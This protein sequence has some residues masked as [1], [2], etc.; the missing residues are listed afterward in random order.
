M[1]LFVSI[2]YNCG[3]LRRYSEAID[4]YSRAVQLK[5]DFAVGWY[6]VGLF[7]F[8]QHHYRDAVLASEKALA[9]NPDYDAP[10]VIIGMEHRRSGDLDGA[11]WSFKRAIDLNPSFVEAHVNL[12]ETYLRRNEID[13]A[14]RELQWAIQSAP[15]RARIYRETL[16]L[17]HWKRGEITNAAGEWCKAI[18]LYLRN[19]I[20]SQTEAS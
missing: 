18:Y 17:A 7:H 13:S 20:N 12:G 4:A 19:R 16:A 10:Y 15:G 3:R 1:T 14:M 8:H 11:V 2:G 5:P 9:I 6:N